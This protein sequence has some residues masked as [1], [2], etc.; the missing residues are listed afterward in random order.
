M[1]IPL[2]APSLTLW[3]LVLCLV[4]YRLSAGQS[5]LLYMY[6]LVVL[7]VSPIELQP[8]GGHGAHHGRVV[9]NLDLYT[10]LN[11][12]HKKTASAGGREDFTHEISLDRVCTIR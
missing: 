4:C 3:Y 5:L 6:V 7:I 2:N 9:N 11:M 12:T 10:S 8:T 1:S